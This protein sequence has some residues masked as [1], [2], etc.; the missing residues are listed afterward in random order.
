MEGEVKM[1]W[2]RL[3]VEVLD[4]EKMAKL[5]DT[6]YRIFT[7]LML[8]A[9]EKDQ[10]GTFAFSPQDIAWRLR[11]PTQ[12][13]INTT[14]KLQELSIVSIDNGMLQF[15]NW[16]KRQYKSDDVTARVKRYREKGETLQPTL[17]NRNR[18]ET[19]QKQSRA[20]TVT[21]S[22]DNSE[23]EYPSFDSVTPEKEKA[24]LT[25]KQKKPEPDPD[26][27]ELQ[28]LVN[29][30]KEKHPR[31]AI[32]TW[33]G[34]N[35]RAHPMAIIHVLRSLLKNGDDADYP[36][37]YLQSA[38]NVENGKYNARDSEA[39]HEIRKKPVPGEMQNMRQILAHVGM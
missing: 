20:E 38:L 31:L 2:L 27:T 33:Y 8:M 35:M 24:A 37:A 21:L 11:R 32:E 34:K 36:F 15:I 25:E 18:T 29:Q 10:N 16:N 6:Q 7:Y 22:V 23:P 5:T 14:E 30:V 9:R 3:Y 28:S 4:D 26:T 1:D 13:I 39:E 19:E 12:Q 17:E